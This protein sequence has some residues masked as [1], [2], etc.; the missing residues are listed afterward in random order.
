MAKN[1]LR[2]RL[3]LRLLVHGVVSDADAE[4]VV[5]NIDEFLDRYEEKDLT[6][7]KV[8]TLYKEIRDRMKK[9]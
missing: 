6:M 4:D 7:D 5:S 2:E 1:E 9:N 3:I 8:E